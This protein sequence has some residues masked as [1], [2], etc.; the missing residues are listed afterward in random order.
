MKKIVFV[1]LCL[2]SF[3]GSA[4][5]GQAIP[6][7]IIVILADDLGYGDVGFNG[8]PDIPTPNIDSIAANGVLC[9]NGYATHPFCSPSRAGLMTGRYQQRFGYENNLLDDDANPRLGL[10]MTELLLPQILK[11]AGYVCGAIGKWHLGAAFNFH[12]L[13]RGF[14]EFFG[15]LSGSSGYLNARVLQGETWITETDYLTDAFTRE[16]ESF[17]TRHASEPFFLYL[18]Y[19]APHA[20]FRATP[21]YLDRVA[22]ISDS[23]RRVLAAMVVAMDDGIGGV[24]ETL[25]AENLLD[26]T[27]I[28]FLSDNGAPQLP[29]TRN[30]P[31]RGYKGDVYDGGIRVPFAVQWKGRLPAGVLYSSPISSLDIVPTVAA[32]AG[33][34]L[35]VDR[36][37]DGLNVVP[38][39][40]GEQKSPVRTLFWR[41]FGLG[42]QG[43]P[44]SLDTIYAVRNGSYKLVQERSTPGVP[45]LYYLSNDISEANDLALSL[46]GI[47]NSLQE[48]YARWSVGTIPP[49]WQYSSDFLGGFPPSLVLA[50]DW[51][52][53]NKDDAAAPWA[54]PRN[55]APMDPPTPDGYNFF[56]TTVHVAE[57]GADTRPG[58]HSFVLIGGHSYLNQWGGAVINVNGTTS[59][60]FFS[61]S[62][63]GSRNTIT[64]QDGYYSFR[65]LDPGAPLHSAL[66]LAVMKTS[67]PPV[68]VSRSSQI[69]ARPKAGVAVVVNITTSQPICPEERIYVR[70]T[71]DSFVTSN[72]VL[73]AGSGTTY[74]AT[75]PAQSSSAFVQ[76]TIVSATVDFGPAVSAG[77]VDPLLLATSSVFNAR[78][79]ALQ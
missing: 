9:T 63:L 15:F 20:P 59:I 38:Y 43:P 75:I 8:C 58:E 16:A 23:A 61:G 6:P 11:P 31:L 44:G 34:A 21:E 67:A 7:N 39:L 2:L 22:F 55:S 53:F 5:R 47:V 26:N 1:L 46:P 77:A 12:P 52:A 35:P 49:L 33:V 45:S 79:N 4:I 74:T 78:P 19:N 76:Y 17:I 29:F 54:L 30:L 71:T 69:P 51:N 73:A 68:T 48:R 25:E 66:R 18:A 50:G 14:D 41:W 62:S 27:L 70:W 24:L 60:P 13:Q 40:A 64:L 32:A 3:S 28:F 37:Y 72:F 57:S 65:Y 56:A 36:V 42:E 10:P